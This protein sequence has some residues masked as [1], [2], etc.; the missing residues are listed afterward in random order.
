MTEHI[1]TTAPADNGTY[2]YWEVRDETGGAS[3]SLLHSRSEGF[4]SLAADNGRLAQW[5]STTESGH[6]VFNVVGIH[7]QGSGWGCSVHGDSC[8]EDALGDTLALPL[9]ARL[10]EAGVTDAGVFAELEQLHQL[11]FGE[12]AA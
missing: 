9:W 11:V 2:H 6:W 1:H 4:F 5:L 7:R 10:R 8:D 3:V 12:V